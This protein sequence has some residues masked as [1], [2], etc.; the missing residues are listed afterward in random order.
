MLEMS[1][2]NQHLIQSYLTVLEREQVCQ[3]PQSVL[4]FFS[5]VSQQK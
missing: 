2:C 3:D 4:P 5:S 1:V